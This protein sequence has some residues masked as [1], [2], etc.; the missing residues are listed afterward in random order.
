MSAYRRGRAAA[1][2]VRPLALALVV[3]TTQVVL[4][5]VSP[6][7]ASH[8]D[9]TPTIPLLT[10]GILHFEGTASS[11][12][13]E[14]GDVAYPHYQETMS[15]LSFSADYLIMGDYAADAANTP[16]SNWP[17]N[18]A[19]NENPPLTWSS[20]PGTDTNS[21]GYY[22]TCSGTLS[23]GE[24]QP[25]SFGDRIPGYDRAT[26]EFFGVGSSVVARTG[27]CN[28]PDG[29]GV[30]QMS[31]GAEPFQSANGLFSF[32]TTPYQGTTLT[33]PV[34]NTV[35]Y[36][37]AGGG[38]GQ[39]ETMSGTMTLSCA[40]CVS[41]IVFRQLVDP[42]TGDQMQQL[43]NNTTYD[44]NVLEVSATV[45]NTSDRTLTSIVSFGDTKTEVHEAQGTQL[46]QPV[47]FPAGS[48]KTVTESIDT[49]GMAWLGQH[50]Q[51]QHTIQV[52]T[53]FGGAQRDLTI[54]PK[55]V[56]LVHGWNA[57]ATT[58]DAMKNLLA[59][60]DP[61]WPVF[62]VGDAWAQA[63]ETMDTDPATGQWISAN[64]AAE[65]KYIEHVRSMTGAQHVDL[66]VHSMGGLISRY[67]ID[68]LML[69]QPHPPG[70][71]PLVSHLVMLGT[72][73]M[74]SPCAELVSAPAVIAGGGRPTLQLTTAYISLVFD[75]QITNQH[76]VPFSVIAGTGI[77]TCLSLINGD[78]VVTK[79]SAWW[80]YTDVGTAP[81]DLHTTLPHDPAVVDNWVM[82]HIAVSSDA[83]WT[84]TGAP[85][86]LTQRSVRRAVPTATTTGPA[87]V[88]ALATSI[89]PGGSKTLTAPVTG[90]AT[91][92][93][94]TLVANPSVT[95]RVT[96]PDGRIA[97]SQ[98]SSSPH[99]ADPFRM[100]SVSRPAAGRWT[101]RL[102]NTGTSAAS[103]M[104]S[105]ELEGTSTLA[106]AT[107]KALSG[108]RLQISTR[109]HTG[110]SPI[111]GASA[112]AYLRG[113]SGRLVTV[114][115]HDDGRSGDAHAR[116]GVYTA[117][118][119]ALPQGG[120]VVA[121]R[122]LRKSVSRYAETA[123]RVP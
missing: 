17:N 41:N 15:G 59:A 57:D 26:D 118:T 10:G 93:A 33:R 83:Y 40:L 66:V 55:P 123:A 18:L 107:A 122:L 99:A 97:A 42:T 95:I 1:R 96:R 105:A 50:P 108:R 30:T 14:I 101:I 51:A 90:T 5:A 56:V 117:R 7:P 120:Y 62:A 77:P 23:W 58:W 92:L 31:G 119:G 37:D 89:A 38:S 81:G 79:D 88:S 8:A 78:I 45:H 16:R 84:P 100:I 67:Y 69:D 63:G 22:G 109:L 60:K 53:A 11:S 87:V 114:R 29:E 73:N 35:N 91:T 52:E 72:P 12:I 13:D 113:D 20:T 19:D 9:A 80:D 61:Q 36:P 47:T 34:S 76:G 46:L 6:L 2:I 4:G 94:T 28:D 43:P 110:R 104:A 102:T 21:G 32:P 111:T 71:R 115:L 85:K 49:S 121:V 39:T 48:T 24:P 74:G 70:G 75:H 112:V 27:Q 82:P 44:G 103:V 25:T 65:A 106:T 98:T 86:R 68:R 116:D 54:L 3:A 64:A